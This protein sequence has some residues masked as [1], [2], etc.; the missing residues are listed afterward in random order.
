[1]N[2]FARAF[3]W[4]DELIVTDIYSAFEEPIEGITA[5][6]LVTAIREASTLPCHYVSKNNLIEKIHSLLLPHDVV[7]TI[8][9]GDIT[10]LH[11]E[12]LGSFHPKKITLGLIFGGNSCEHEISLRSSRFV[13]QSLNRSLYDIRYFGIDK[14]G[15]MDRRGG[16]R[17]AV[18]DSKGGAI[19]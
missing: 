12:L 16:G 9:A 5:E 13:A 14:K 8:G 2:D 17:E 1:M 6:S 4:G 10:H 18:G 15:G 7:L 3:E 11:K 19:Q